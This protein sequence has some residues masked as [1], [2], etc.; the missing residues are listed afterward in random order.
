AKHAGSTPK[1]EP[2]FRQLVK[3]GKKETEHLS[4]IGRM[5]KHPAYQEIVALGPAVVPLLL[6]ELRREP[7]FWFP[8]LRAIT[9][10]NPEPPESVGKVEE[11]AAAWLE[12]GRAKGLLL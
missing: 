5:V 12:W 6:A 8:A 9:Q 7:D 3:R 11:Q 1:I 2:R 4:V 10:E